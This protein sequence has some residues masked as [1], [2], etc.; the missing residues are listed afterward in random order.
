M[1]F[2]LGLATINPADLQESM[3]R[4]VLYG[5]LAAA[6]VAVAL[7]RWHVQSS[8]PSTAGDTAP[9]T[10]KIDEQLFSR[11]PEPVMAE[12]VPL[13]SQLC[14]QSQ[15][16]APVFARWREELKLP[17][18]FHSKNWEYIFI[19]K[20]LHERGMLMPGKRGVGFGVGKE[21]LPALFAKYGAQVVATDLEMVE[22]TKKGWV[23]GNQHMDSIDVLNEKGIADPVTFR[24]LVTARD[25]DMTA[26]PQDLTE[27]DFTWSTCALG[28]LGNLAAARKFIE[29]SL[30]TLKP[31]GV[32]VHT[33]E[34][35]LSSNAMTYE[36]ANTSVFRRRDIEELAARLRAQGHDIDVTF[37]I[38]SGE[39]DFYV[40]PPPYSSDKHLRLQLGGY[41]LTSLG[42]IIRKSPA[43]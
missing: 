30:K 18:T 1:H 17:S 26:I 39:L 5:V 31:G 43:S 23:E 7:F 20:A 16:S 35:N 41:A 28:H 36:T 12:G 33:T 10:P 42:I 19:T 8:P 32:A 25:V 24:R 15:F 21:Q 11:F 2:E 4:F 13:K 22:A 38:G 37:G 29:D 27:F 34:L 9:V 40:D 6:V 3:K 14:T